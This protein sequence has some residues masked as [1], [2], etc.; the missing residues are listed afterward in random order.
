VHAA[1]DAA[2]FES[3]TSHAS[4]RG[5]G[6]Q[7]DTGGLVKVRHLSLAIHASLF[8][9]HFSIELSHVLALSAM[10]EC[11]N[12]CIPDC[13]NSLLYLAANISLTSCIDDELQQMQQSQIDEYRQPS[14]LC[15]IL[16]FSKKPE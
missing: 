5:Y 11:A 2:S 16:K 4:T 9:F 6:P 10:R 1:T 12:E 7:Y 8:P 13:I 15:V 3:Q 14:S